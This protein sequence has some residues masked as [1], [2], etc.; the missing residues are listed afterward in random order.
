MSPDEKGLSERD[1]QDNS[2]QASPIH[3]MQC[4]RG[5]VGLPVVPASLL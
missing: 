3:E 5:V 1:T 4:Q 2:E